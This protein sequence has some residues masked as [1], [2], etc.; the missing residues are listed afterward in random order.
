M[1]DVLVTTVDLTL[2]LTFDIP[3]TVHLR[4][5]QVQME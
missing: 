2:W 3:A 4:G 5:A 1:A